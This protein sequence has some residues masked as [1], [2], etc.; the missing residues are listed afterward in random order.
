LRRSTFH[1][2]STF[3]NGVI[4]L[5]GVTNWLGDLAVRHFGINTHVVE[6]SSDRGRLVIV[7]AT[8]N[9]V[10]HSSHHHECQTDDEE[11]DPDDQNNVGEGEGRGKTWE[12][13]SEDNED[14]SEDD[15]GV[16][17]VSLQDIEGKI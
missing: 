5:W 13:E 1:D 4:A 15:H 14:N 8:A 16:Y 7:A 10:A 3:H 2:G 9:S 12:E 17:L 11:D 6:W